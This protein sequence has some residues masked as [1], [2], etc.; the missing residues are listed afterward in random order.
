MEDQVVK[1]SLGKAIEKVG[2]ELGGK[3]VIKEVAE[4]N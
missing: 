3:K 4:F 2:K 1:R